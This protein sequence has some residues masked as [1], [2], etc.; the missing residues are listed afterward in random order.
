M[1]LYGITE[2]I[3]NTRLIELK[4]I[5]KGKGKLFAKMEFIQPG[6]SVKNRAALQIIKDAYRNKKLVKGQPVVEMTSGNMGAGL[7]V[8]CAAFGNPFIAVMS[9]GNSK[10]RIKILKALGAEV[11]LTPH[12]LP[13]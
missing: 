4:N 9:E 10:E 5:Y 1:K 7:A 3:T 6:G 13:P 12:D 8:V 2:F 11:V